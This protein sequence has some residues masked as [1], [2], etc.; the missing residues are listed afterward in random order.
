MELLDLAPYSTSDRALYDDGAV[1]NALRRDPSS[2]RRRYD[3][4]A[5]RPHPVHPLLLAVGLG[6]SVDVV[7]AIHDAQIDGGHHRLRGETDRYGRTALHYASE[8]RA[9]ADVVMLLLEEASDDNSDGHVLA[10]GAGA[11]DYIGR[12]PLHCACAYNA[13]VEVV[14]ILVDARPGTVKE[15]DRRKRTPLHVACSHE[16][17]LDVVRML[18]ERHP[19]AV[20]EM[21][22]RGATPLEIVEKSNAASLDM[23]EVMQSLSVASRALELR[24]GEGAKAMDLLQE[25]VAMNWSAGV[26]LVLD[27][28]PSI[29]H[30]LKLNDTMKPQLLCMVGRACKM[31]TM[32]QILVTMPCLFV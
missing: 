23:L 29:V 8:F 16:A 17:S 10:A 9:S 27:I 4:N 19:L 1:M 22:G 7:R 13:S 6:A 18:L 26:A 20:Q 5:T 12:T 30:L 24:D 15:R 32:L 3:F 11:R 28:R 31:Q 2:A 21:D 14:R 25:T